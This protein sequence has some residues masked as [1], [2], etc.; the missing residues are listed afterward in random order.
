MKAVVVQ[1][2]GGYAVRRSDLLTA[3][4][5]YLHPARTLRARV[6]LL[7]KHAVITWARYLQRT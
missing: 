7:G 4:R 3:G 6:A 5:L 1:L 2:P